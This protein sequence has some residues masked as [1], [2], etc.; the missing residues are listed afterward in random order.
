M[1]MAVTSE[2]FVGYSAARPSRNLL[3]FSSS[4]EF[5]SARQTLPIMKNRSSPKDGLLR[6]LWYE[7]L[8]QRLEALIF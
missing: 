3:V 4:R 1:V 6:F 5:A 7:R 2:E 8:F